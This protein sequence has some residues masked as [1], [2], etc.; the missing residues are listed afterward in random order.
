MYI[1][2]KVILFLWIIGCSLS[3]CKAT[4]TQSNNNKSLLVITTI[5]NTLSDTCLFPINLHLRLDTT[6]NNAMNLLIYKPNQECPSNI[7]S[8]AVITLNNRGNMYKNNVAHNSLPIG[9]NIVTLALLI[10]MVVLLVIIVLKQTTRQSGNNGTTADDPNLT[11][12]LEK[13]GFKNIKEVSAFINKLKQ[14]NDDLLDKLEICKNTIENWETTIGFDNPKT[15]K[16]AIDNLKRDSNTLYQAYDEYEDLLRILKNNPNSLKGNK[17]FSKLST[18]IERAEYFDKI[19]DNPDLID[20]DSKTGQIIK[21][22]YDFEHCLETPQIVLSASEYKS[23][24]LANYLKKGKLLDEIKNNIGLIMSDP[25]NEFKNTDLKNMLNF[26]YTPETI[27]NTKYKDNGLYK[28]ITSINNLSTQN[29]TNINSINYEWLKNRLSIIIENANQYLV[30]A[31]VADYYGTNDMDTSK[32]DGN[33]KKIFDNAVKYLQLGTYKDYWKNVSGQ[34]LPALN[35]LHKNDDT[36]NSRLLLFYTSQLY[37]ISCIM[38]KIYGDYRLST[39]R[40]ETNISLFNAKHPLSLSKY[41][42]PVSETDLNEY[43]F[44]YKGDNDEYN[45]IEFLKK[46]KPLPFIFINS[47]Y[48]DNILK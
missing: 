35:N 31:S 13:L 45:R 47:Y 36:Y 3:F 9:L 26:I 24:N 2:K 22:G 33:V 32:L 46:Y 10:A 43:R 25:Y 34:L 28:L 17:R 27:S 8:I 18:I 44:E 11:K 4:E 42:I 14:D 20:K 6:D 29:C 19:M 41:G 23:T 39:K 15:A 30:V 37:S 1:M 40:F 48:S 7:D 5:D 21:K 38:S 16:K 12:G